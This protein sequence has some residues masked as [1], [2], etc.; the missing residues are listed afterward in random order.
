MNVGLKS[1]PDGVIIS[2][3]AQPGARRNGVT[4]IHDNRLKVAVTQVAEKGKANQQIIKVLAE[5]LDVPKSSLTVVS[6]ETSS[7]KSILVLGATIE[8]LNAKLEKLS[9]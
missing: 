1:V 2:V 6:G 5:F 9:C 7:R 8:G 3:Q 4:G